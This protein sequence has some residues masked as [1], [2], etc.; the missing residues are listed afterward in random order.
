MKEQLTHFK[1]LKVIEEDEKDPQARWRAHEV[2]FSYVVFVAQQ[3]WGIIGFQI[4]AK[5]VF[6]ITSICTNL[7]RS[8]LSM[9][10]LEMLINIYKI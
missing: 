8:Q 9:D 2:H 7:K 6:N 5:K 3:I 10:N 1:I 4:E